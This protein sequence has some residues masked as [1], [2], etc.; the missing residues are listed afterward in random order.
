MKRKCFVIG[1]V[2]FL[3]LALAACTANG[4]GAV[5]GTYGDAANVLLE[6]KTTQ[7]F[8]SEKVAAE[9]VEKILSAGVNAPSAMN[10]QPWHFT[11]V[12]DEE[13][14]QKLADAMKNMKP[15][16]GFEGGE[17]KAPP[18]AATFLYYPALW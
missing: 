1:A 17:R 15:P 12:T 6:A 13:V 16:A 7:F 18:K 9:D 5:S 8:S 2:I 14:A 3:V 10:T 4:D 11:A